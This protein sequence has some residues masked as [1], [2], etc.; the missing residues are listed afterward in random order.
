[1]GPVPKV[2]VSLFNAIAA[3]AAGRKLRFEF[4]MQLARELIEKRGIHRQTSDCGMPGFNS[5]HWF[6][7]GCHDVTD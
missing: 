5:L 1:M 3:A 6:M 2:F 4:T 7:H